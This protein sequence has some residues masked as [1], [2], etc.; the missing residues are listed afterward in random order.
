MDSHQDS[1]NLILPGTVMTS[2]MMFNGKDKE[3]SGKA[4]EE[5]LSDY[6]AKIQRNHVVDVIAKRTAKS[7]SLSQLFVQSALQLIHAL[8]VLK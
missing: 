2:S 1:D 5:S 6:K 3:K 7:L 8:I 4:P